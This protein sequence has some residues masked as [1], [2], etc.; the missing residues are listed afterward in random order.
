M[1]PVCS[2]SRRLSKYQSRS[3][4]SNLPETPFKF[5]NIC[6]LVSNL[7]LYFSRFSLS[8]NNLVK[9]SWSSSL[10]PWNR[11]RKIYWRM[12][13]ISTGPD[14]DFLLFLF[15]TRNRNSLCFEFKSRSRETFPSYNSDDPMIITYNHRNLIDVRGVTTA[16]GDDPK[17]HYKQV[18]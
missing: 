3:T 10:L 1:L 12:T 5:W 11:R 9:Y 4:L 6:A 14:R 13:I 15:L 16:L 17:C 2:V 7:I 8:M 18:V